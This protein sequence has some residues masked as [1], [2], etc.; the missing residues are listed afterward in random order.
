MTTRFISYLRPLRRRWGLTQRE[1]AF[2]IGGKSGGAV[3]RL[4][5]LKRGPTLAT[6]I[7]CEIIFKAAYERLFPERY[8]EIREAV[9]ARVNELYE[10][11]Q[12]HPSRVTRAKLD[13]L[14]SILAREERTPT[15]L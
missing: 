3:S 5:Q 10:A 4:E 6:A 7:A 14:E 12:G 15:D 11:L 13:F 8:A 9:L 2:L 1:L